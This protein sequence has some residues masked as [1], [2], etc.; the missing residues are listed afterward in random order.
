MSDS[1]TQ[2]QYNIYVDIDNT[3]CKT[4]STDYTKATPIQANIDKVNKLYDHP[5]NIYRITYWTARG[6][7]T[8]IDWTELT[9]T[10][11]HQW[12]A[13][14]HELKL[15]KPA[16]DLLIDDK[17]INS[18]WGWIPAA[19]NEVLTPGYIKLINSVTSSPK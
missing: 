5:N 12:G 18:I 15:S 3:I 7:K 8:K 14:Y 16:F 17:A 13:K 19:I 6:Q 1:S 9:K 10:Q 2:L 4:P 11:L